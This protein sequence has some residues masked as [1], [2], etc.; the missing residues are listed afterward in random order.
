MKKASDDLDDGSLGESSGGTWREW[1]TE[2]EERVHKLEVAVAERNHHGITEEAAV[3]RVA[4]K[5]PVSN[6]FPSSPHET[7]GELVLATPREIPPPPPK[8]AV[9]H[10]PEQS[11]PSQR[12]WF[13]TQ[14]LAEFRLAI[15]MYFDPR[16]RISRTTQFALPGIVLLVLINY[17]FITFW[18]DI[19]ILSPILERAI[20]LLL[21]VVAY[22]LLTRELL[23]Y[24]DVLNYLSRYSSY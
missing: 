13:L 14:L 23:R 9:P 20:D 21:C 1:R 22:K 24:R 8:G 19:P 5:L 4:T 3:D 17:F 10:P 11:D 16:Y 15:H 18:L 6:G 2:L 7:T 12:T